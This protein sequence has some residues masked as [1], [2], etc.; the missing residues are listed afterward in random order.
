LENSHSGMSQTHPGVFLQADLDSCDNAALD[1]VEP[2]S[3]SRS[4]VQT[5][6]LVA[7][8]PSLHRLG[9]V[10]GIVVDDQMQIEIGRGLPVDGFEEA[11]EFAMA[12]AGHALADDATVKHVEGGK[13]GGG[14]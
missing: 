2:G 10:G 14:A 5:K 1:H 13:Q 7:L 12:M 3:R 9:L 4:E 6:A 8:E 11:Q